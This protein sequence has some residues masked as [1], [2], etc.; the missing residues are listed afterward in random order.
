MFKQELK[1]LEADVSSAYSPSKP[2]YSHSKFS[3]LHSLSEIQEHFLSH[4]NDTETEAKFLK[5]FLH[6]R[7]EIKQ[8]C[9]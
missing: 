8:I 7:K 9:F 3:K 5:C 4:K 2:S 6:S 1:L